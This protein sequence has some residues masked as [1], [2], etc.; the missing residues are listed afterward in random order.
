MES[1]LNPAERVLMRVCLSDR[2]L[3]FVPIVRHN[4]M[5]NLFY[6]QVNFAVSGVFPIIFSLRAHKSFDREE[7]GLFEKSCPAGF[8]EK[9]FAKDADGL[10]VAPRGKNE[11]EP[12]LAFAGGFLASIVEHTVELAPL[13]RYWNQ[14]VVVGAELPEG[15]QRRKG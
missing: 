5:E 7:S 3:S 11:W 8:S 10:V 9:K 12:R 15:I 2:H 1:L 13:R 4:F 6:P 14:A